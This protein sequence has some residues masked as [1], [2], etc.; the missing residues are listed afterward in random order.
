MT[1]RRTSKYRLWNFLLKRQIL[2]IPVYL[3]EVLLACGWDI[4]ILKSTP[5]EQKK[6][7]SRSAASG[8]EN[9]KSR[10]D[11]Y[12][13]LLVGLVRAFSISPPAIPKVHHE[14][15]FRKVFLGANLF[16]G[17]SIEFRHARTLRIG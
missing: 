1:R 16:E 7:L 8:S 15:H 14:L 12:F 17:L 4:L 2:A 6:F 9:G 10:V 3:R 11:I 13:I 5:S